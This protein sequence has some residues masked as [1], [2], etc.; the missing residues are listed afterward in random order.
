MKLKENNG[1]HC[2]LHNAESHRSYSR[3]AKGKP[4]QI[5]FKAGERV[6]HCKVERHL[7]GSTFTCEA[8]I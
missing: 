6:Y 7:K 2:S 5:K 1:L 8:S 3:L 4:C